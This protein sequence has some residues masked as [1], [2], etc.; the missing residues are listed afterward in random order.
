MGYR[1]QL[2]N[3]V[4]ALAGAALLIIHWICCRVQAGHASVAHKTKYSCAVFKFN[5]YRSNATAIV[6]SELNFLD[7]QPLMLLI[8]AHCPALVVPVAIQR[9]PKL[10]GFHIYNCTI[11]E[12]SREASLS[13]VAHPRMT[14]DV[15]DRSLGIRSRG[16]R[17]CWVYKP[18]TLCSRSR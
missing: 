7:E 3:P 10:L 12:W 9:F 6:T 17:T 16:H 8:F 14:Y 11:A 4:I 2:V 15:R 18:T 1:Y 13:V 5:C